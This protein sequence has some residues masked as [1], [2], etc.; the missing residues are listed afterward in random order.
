MAIVL[1]AVVLLLLSGVGVLSIG[2]TARVFSIRTSAEVAARSAAD[3][4]ITKALWAMNTKLKAGTWD[5]HDLLWEFREELP[6]SDAIYSYLVAKAD[7]YYGDVMPTGDDALMDFFRS[8][9][10]DDG[11]YI[12][13]A[14]GR[15]GTARKAIY[16]TARLKGCGD[17]GVLAREK[18]IL[19]PYTL[20]DARDS[21]D[22]TN[23][24]PDIPLEIGTTSTAAGAIVLFHNV[25]VDGNVVVGVG[26][27]V[28][29]VIKDLDAT[30]GLQYPMIEEPELPLIYPP[31][32]PDMP[33]IDIKA[34]TLTVGPAQS[35][36]Y[37][38][39][40]LKNGPVVTILEIK[41]GDVVI[42]VTGDIDLGYDCEIVITEGSTLNLYVDGDIRAGNAEGFNNQGT[43]PDLKL[44]GN[45]RGADVEQYWELKAKSEYFG[46]IY[47]PGADILVHAKG[48]LY[49]AFTA[50]SFE[51][52][53][54]GNLY[55]DG[56]LRE[57]DPGDEGVR[58]VLKRWYE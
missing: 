20:V 21:R 39:I 10:A 53:S 25:T 46:Q 42:H 4:G 18:L 16:G 49:G 40:E 12:I 24:N 26:G 55:Y 37:S 17:T 29:T 9:S 31:V 15:Y 14:L 47:A 2:Q 35:G 27:D 30:T 6:N 52:K 22:P 43:P 5:G 41:G 32:L 36:R 23:L 44:W 28:E 56:A 19:K 3:S 58:F 38:S 34:E 33:D 1:F 45:W 13:A 48:D 57:V 8:A 50:E 51:M 11:D 7:Y 54:G